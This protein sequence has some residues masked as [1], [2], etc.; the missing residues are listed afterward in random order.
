MFLRYS[1]FEDRSNES[2]KF[3][4]RFCIANFLNFEHQILHLK[5]HS[6]VTFKVVDEMVR[7]MSYVGFSGVVVKGRLRFLKS[8]VASVTIFQRLYVLCQVRRDKSENILDEKLNLLASKI[9]T[10]SF[11]MI[12]RSLF[13]KTGNTVLSRNCHSETNSQ[14]WRVCLMKIRWR[15]FIQ[16]QSFHRGRAISTCTNLA[17]SGGGG[18][19]CVSSTSGERQTPVASR[20]DYF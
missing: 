3:T 7:K 15:E 2:S 16:S 17:I 19:F 6:N 12:P 14:R 8:I 5:L 18:G 1:G 20:G 10:S 13:S 9:E 11:E 4:V